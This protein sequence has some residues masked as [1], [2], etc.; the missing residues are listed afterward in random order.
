M[1]R[2]ELNLLGPFQVRLGEQPVT[3]FESVKVRALLACLAVEAARPQ[4]RE[5]LAELLWPDWPQ[6][7]AMSNLRYALADLR[8]G[9]GDRQAQPALLLINRESIQLNPAANIHVDVVEFETAIRDPRTS[10]TDTQLSISNLQSAISLYR[11]DFLEGFSLDDNPP[12]EE[13]LLAKRAY[14]NQQALKALSLLTE[15]GIDQRE[16]EQAEGYA[17]RQIEL[18]PWREQA[19]QQLMRTLS[20]KGERVQALAQYESLRKALQRELMV[21]PSAETKQLYKN[22]RDEEPHGIKERGDGVPSSHTSLSP[23]PLSLIP[24]S[25]PTPHPNNLPHHLTS[26]IGRQEE[27]NTVRRLLSTHRLVT[28]TGAGGVGKTRLALQA[29]SG[30]TEDFPDGIFVTELSPLI[31]PDML[32]QAVLSSLG[33]KAE[34]NLLPLKILTGYYQN[35][36]SL[37]I[38]DNC[39]HLVESCAHFSD[40]LLRACPGLHILVTS[41]EILSVSGEAVFQVPP[42]SIPTGEAASLA[43]VLQSDAARLFAARASSVLPDFAVDAENAAAIAQVCRRLDGIPMA[44]ELAA[45]RVNLLTVEEIAQ[46]LD[47]CFRLLTGGSRTALPKQKTL[48]G[49]IDWSWDLLPESEKA[50]FNMLSVFAGGWSLETA[51]SLAENP[52]ETLDMLTSLAN[53]SMIVVDHP[54]GLAARYRML[55]TLRQYGQEKLAESGLKSAT[56]S[57]HRDFFLALAESAEPELKGYGQIQWLKRLDL[58]HDNLRAALEWSFLAKDAQAA[59]RLVGALSYYWAIR[60]NGD[61]SRIYTQRALDL[62]KNTQDMLLSPWKAKVLLGSVLAFD[63]YYP[64]DSASRQA[65]VEQALRLF[66]ERGDKQGIGSALLILSNL[67][68]WAGDIAASELQVEQSLAIMQE[69]KNAWGIANCLFQYRLIAE[70]KEER[71]KRLAFGEEGI[72]V[73]KTTGD[74]WCLATHLIELNWEIWD[75]GN[76]EKSRL[77]SEETLQIIREIGDKF[78]EALILQNLAYMELF[79]GDHHKARSLAENSGAIWSDLGVKIHFNNYT[80]GEIALYTGNLVEAQAM[81][82]AALHLAREENV[83]DLHGLSLDG[84]GRCSYYQ[85][86]YPQARALLLE[87]L[88]KLEDTKGKHH[89]RMTLRDLGDVAR[90]QGETAQAADWYRKSLA[91]IRLLWSNPFA[92][93]TIE[94]LAK[95]AGMQDQPRRAVRLFAAAQAARNWMETPLPPVLH[96]DYERNLKA[97]GEALGQ[98]AFTAAWN[99]GFALT[100]EQAVEYALEEHE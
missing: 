8:K 59:L 78:N 20:L 29:A 51:E 94:G 36:T 63:L 40:T 17:R 79:H 21:E 24:G 1:A 70:A 92:P 69:L 39:E 16:Y 64:R 75:Y 44:I 31:N 30:M 54:P 55:E 58:E 88:T 2:L 25:R 19:H 87:S 34:A 49:L 10:I 7:S 45:V 76:T 11:G 67:S 96:S 22:I 65:A 68:M 33:L 42:L 62:A 4:L 14:F 93:E 73:I 82:D 80:M 77:L 12:F 66:Q 9:I 53:K 48:R 28:L 99:E 26:F 97:V 74:R 50:F 18:E 98:E 72:A 15:W 95:V 32:H 100:L 81:F 43:T 83:L 46:R 23:A 90:L 85:G 35:K 37:I 71:S 5:R 91:I 52:G 27:I 13:W 57:R 41:R 47:D 86:K 61:E 89:Q 84:L 3:S 60:W 56:H 38:L 6:Q